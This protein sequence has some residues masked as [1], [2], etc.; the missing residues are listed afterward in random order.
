[1]IFG[2]SFY[3]LNVSQEEKPP[4]IERLGFYSYVSGVLLLVL[5]FLL[6]GANG[7]PRRWAVYLPEWVSYA[8]WGTLA[9]VLVVLGVLLFAI[10]VLPMLPKA[11]E[12][13]PI[14]A[15]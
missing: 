7:I 12:P 10:R 15:H 2:F 1:M 4:L 3:L 5:V 9:A 6:S 13:E 14:P 8:Q 11:V